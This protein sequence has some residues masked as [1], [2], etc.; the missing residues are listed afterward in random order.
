MIGDRQVLEHC[1]RVFDIAARAEKQ[2]SD[3]IRVQIKVIP[4]LPNCPSVLLGDSRDVLF[5]IPTRIDRPGDNYARQDL[6]GVLLLEDKAGGSEVCY[7]FEELFTKLVQFSAAVIKVN[8]GN[9]HH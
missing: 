3:R 2:G 7:P 5:T 1:M 4:F 9:P 8:G 6:L